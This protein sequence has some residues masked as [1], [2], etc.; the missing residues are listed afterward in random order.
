MLPRW[1]A[2]TG[3]GRGFRRVR[4]NTVRGC[5]GCPSYRVEGAG[6]PRRNPD[7]LRSTI[8]LAIHSHRGPCGAGCID[9]DHAC[10]V[11]VFGRGG[12]GV[13]LTG[14]L[15]C[16][17]VRRRASW[18]VCPRWP[19]RAGCVL[20]VAHRRSRGVRRSSSVHTM[21]WEGRVAGK[22]AGRGWPSRLASRPDEPAASPAAVRPAGNGLAAVELL[23]VLTCWPAR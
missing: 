18:L 9:A 10:S 11:R 8:S 2:T 23:R 5:W 1:P 15:L 7:R 3:R 20:L 14:V 4:A 21:S 22:R 12:P 13:T 6:R 17:S 16:G 19:G